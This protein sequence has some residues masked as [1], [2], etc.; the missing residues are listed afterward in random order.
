MFGKKK[1]KKNEELIDDETVLDNTD[2]KDIDDEYIDD[3]ESENDN[4]LSELEEESDAQLSNEPVVTSKRLSKKEK[5]RLAKEKTNSAFSKVELDPRVVKFLHLDK[6][7][8]MGFFQKYSFK[9]MQESISSY[10]Y[11]YSTRDYMLQSLGMMIVVLVV[12]M[13]SQVHFEY[14]MILLAMAIICTP[15]LIMAYF[16]QLYQLRRF[17]MLQNYLSNIL[18]IFMQNPKISYTLAQLED[19]LDGEI[20]DVVGQARRY[21][22]ETNDDPKLLENALSIIEYSFPNTRVKAAHKLMLSVETGN[23]EHYHD[24]CENLYLDIEGWIRRIYNFQ[25]DLK[26]RRNKLIMLCGASLGMNCIFVYMYSTN[27]FFNGFTDSTGYQLLTAGFIGATFLTAMAVLMKLHGEWLIDDTSNNKEE[28]INETYLYITTHEYKPN[29]QYTIVGVM[30]IIVAIYFALFIHNYTYAGIVT[31]MAVIIL[32]QSKRSYNMKVKMINKA[33]EMEFPVW[34]RDVA[35]SINNLTVV[36]AIE[37]SLKSASYP[38][39]MEIRKFLEDVQTDPTSIRPYNAFLNNYD[40][41]DCQSTM[42]VLYT[43]QSLD[44]KDVTKQVSA[45]IVRNQSLLEKAEAMR[46]SDSL[47]M[48]EA[49]GFLPM[50]LICLQM[51]GSMA[52]MFGHI[53]GKMASMMNGL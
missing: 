9:Q 51:I 41:E 12:G 16:K 50:A 42:K 40:I 4:I 15:M 39:Q 17:E 31:F 29:P 24:V 10:G 47:G 8:K 33:I 52:L 49:L 32:T 11:S 46:N 38:M 21:L 5:K 14:L 37:N 18:P 28:K 19:L 34:L 3:D 22:D 25:K 27:E 44:E 30:M 1:K 6:I 26:D 53:M 43:L 2:E 20:K 35:L 36:N 45:L 48:V 7:K 13:V 23:S